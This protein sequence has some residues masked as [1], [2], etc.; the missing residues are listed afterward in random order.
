MSM[1]LTTLFAAALILGVS[2]GAFAQ[3]LVPQPGPEHEVLKRD[4]GAWD[5]TM[6]ITP[7]PGMPPFSMTGVETNTLLG[8]RWLLTEYKSEMMGQVFEGHGIV[9]Y[10]PTKKAYVSVWADT[11]STSLSTGGEHPG[12]RDEHPDGVVRDAGSGGREDQGEDRRHVARSRRAS[13]QDV[14]AGGGP[15]AL[16]DHD[17]QEA[18]V[19]GARGALRPETACGSPCPS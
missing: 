3:P 2:A 4:V 6:E 16:H 17:L 7:G 8:G 15:A 5:V 13:R 1:R 11:M 14:P 10:D 9:G 18:Q 19:G 12:C